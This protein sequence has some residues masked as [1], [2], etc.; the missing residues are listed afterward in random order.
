VDVVTVGAVLLLALL[1]VAVFYDAL[2][3]RELQLLRRDLA[4][5]QPPAGPQRWPMGV[6]RR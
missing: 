6:H 2:L 4:G 5:R 1:A 3:L